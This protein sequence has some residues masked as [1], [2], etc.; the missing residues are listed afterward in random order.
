[1]IGESR[2]EV[3]PAVVEAHAGLEGYIGHQVAVGIRPEHLADPAFREGGSRLRGQ[4][5]LV[6][7]LGS[8]RLVHLRVAADPIVTEEVLEVAED[9]DA[10]VAEAL[11]AESRAHRAPLVAR[12]DIRSAMRAGELVEAVVDIGHLHFFSLETGVALR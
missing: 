6:E 12:V 4:V 11:Q 5:D 8:E 10:A 9:A 7:A 2:L 3:P 1:V